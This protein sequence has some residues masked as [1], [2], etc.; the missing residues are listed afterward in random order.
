[1]ILCLEGDV[2]ISDILK[3][4]FVD[5]VVIPLEMEQG[6]NICILPEKESDYEFKLRH[7]PWISS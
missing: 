4:L 1:M 3:K 2:G 7:L 6:Q 5:E